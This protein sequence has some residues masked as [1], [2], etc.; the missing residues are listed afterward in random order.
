[1]QIAASY[2]VASETSKSRLILAGDSE[3]DN[4]ATATAAAAATASLCISPGGTSSGKASR[5][6]VDQCD[7]CAIGILVLEALW[8]SGGGDLTV[9]TGGSVSA[10]DA[11]IENWGSNVVSVGKGGRS[12]D[13]RCSRKRCPMLPSVRG[14]HVS[15]G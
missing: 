7:P 5:E 9:T 14:S 10:S 1:M 2:T 4:D 8:P 3:R 6:E 15:E 12:L 11:V 13:N